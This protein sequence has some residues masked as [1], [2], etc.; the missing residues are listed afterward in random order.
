MLFDK[1]PFEK[2]VEMN[3]INNWLLFTGGTYKD[4]VDMA[5]KENQVKVLKL[6]TKQQS[7]N[8]T[9]RI[10]KPTN[11]KFNANDLVFD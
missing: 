11:N 4:I 9:V 10:T 8:G 2:Q 7:T 5:I 6:K 1:L 3:M